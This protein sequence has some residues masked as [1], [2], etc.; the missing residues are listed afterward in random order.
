MSCIV[1]LEAVN[2][3]QDNSTLIEAYLWY[4]LLF[5]FYFLFQEYAC[6][7]LNGYFQLK[8]KAF[9]NMQLKRKMDELTV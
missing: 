2:R 9:G 4:G 8:H 3:K 5:I 7:R 1:K 6:T